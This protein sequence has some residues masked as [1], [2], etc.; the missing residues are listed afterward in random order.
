MNPE[1][2]EDHVSRQVLNV[3]IP[4]FR[5]GDAAG[6]VQLTSEC[7]HEVLSWSK[8]R[9]PGHDKGRVT[10]EPITQRL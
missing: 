5:R 6:E 10:T 2:C 9:L 3:R 7:C 8:G 1:R 4:R